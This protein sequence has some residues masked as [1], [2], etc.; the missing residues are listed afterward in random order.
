MSRSNS[1]RESK[2]PSTA[3]TPIVPLAKRDMNPSATGSKSP[4]AQLVIEPSRIVPSTLHDRGQSSPSIATVDAVTAQPAQELS[5]QS[6]STSKA[7]KVM[8]WFTKKRRAKETLSSLR[9]AGVRSDSTSSFVQVSNSPARKG[10]VDT[11]TVA[12]SSTST[13]DQTAENQ[14]QIT[15]TNAAPESA[16][17]PPEQLPLGNVLQTQQSRNTTPTSSR[18]PLSS[19][20]NK[21]NII[22]PASPTPSKTS[23]QLLSPSSSRRSTP[24]LMIPAR[25]KSLVPESTVSTPGVASEPFSVKSAMLPPSRIPI[26]PSSAGKPDADERKLR[27]HNA[28]VDQLALTSKPPRFVMNEAIRVLREMGIDIRQDRDN[29]FLVKCV[30][31]RRRKGRATIGLGLGSVVSIGSTMGAFTF[32]GNAS[33]SKVSPKCQRDVADDLSSTRAVSQSPLRPAAASCPALPAVLKACSSVGA[34]H[35]RLRRI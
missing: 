27:Y 4:N 29:E 33:T 23:Q 13:V 31:V 24:P 8:D 6:A 28:V 30:R 12:M 5:H 2:R 7:K 11:T 17:I 14:P 3:S 10:V 20:A 16:T 15:I 26:R 21:T 9:T 18:A 35:T 19:A 32:E 1:V 22:P 34:R 25:T